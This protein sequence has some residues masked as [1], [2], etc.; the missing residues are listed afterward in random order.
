MDCGGSCS[1]RVIG[2]EEWMASV[3]RLARASIGGSGLE[4]RRMLVVIVDR[5][6]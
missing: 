3:G 5:S 1:F 4:R 2:L 6:R